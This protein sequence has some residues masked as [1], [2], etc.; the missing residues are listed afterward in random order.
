MSI[1]EKFENTLISIR[2]SLISAVNEKGQSAEENTKIG[3]IPP[4][5]NA[6]EAGDTFRIIVT[7]DSDEFNGQTATATKDSQ[8]ITKTFVDKQAILKVPEAG[9]WT[10]TNSL[11]E[12]NNQVTVGDQ[13][14]LFEFNPYGILDVQVSWDYSWQKTG[15]YNVVLEDKS[16]QQTILDTTGSSLSNYINTFNNV[17]IGTYT[18]KITGG[19][20]GWTLVTQ[21]IVIKSGQTTTVRR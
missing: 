10:I 9:D 14:V 18:F 7:G 1:R 8:Q 13:N 5:I 17:R 12:D 6:I 11:T 21:E 19:T 3:N 4:Y 2:D 16:G 20:Y 15:N